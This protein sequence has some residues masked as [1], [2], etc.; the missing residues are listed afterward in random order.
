MRALLAALLAALALEGAWR[1]VEYADCRRRAHP[2]A[3]AFDLFVVGESTAR[4]YPYDRDAM[5]LAAIVAARFG[6]VIGGRRLL[7][8]TVAESGQSILPQA[9]AL[10]RALACRDPRRPGAAL[11]YTGHNDEGL[12]RGESVLMRLERVLPRSRLLDAVSY[13]LEKNHPALRART[14]DT[15]EFHLRRALAACR[16]AGVTPILATPV[17]DLTGVDPGIVERGASRDELA[18]AARRAR[19]L[20]KAGRCAALDAF[21]AEDAVLH[22]GAAAYMDYRRARCLDRAGKRAEALPLYQSALDRADRSNFGRAT[23]LQLARLRALARETGTPLADAEASLAPAVLRRRAGRFFT[24]AQHPDM[25]GYLILADVYARALASAFGEPLGAGWRTPAEAFAAMK[26]PASCQADALASGGWWLLTVSSNH[27]A[28][29]DRLEAAR[30]RFGEALALDPR[31]FS[32][33]LGS[34]LAHE[35]ARTGMMSDESAL[36]WLGSM[37]LFFV[38]PR[39]LD[40]ARFAEVLARLRAGGATTAALAALER[41]RRDGLQSPH[42]H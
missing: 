27:P 37:G 18:A 7:A 29:E 12:A 2:D 32:A 41:A 17:S 5:S 3:D 25:S 19:S 10:E 16:A 39:D 11:I 21:A 24:D 35:A 40:D 31:N 9:A 15:W 34:A 33:L 22:P 14:L 6:G 42:A 13:F 38:G 20:E 1:G 30:R 26:C 23:S 8:I 36:S 4:G 28:P